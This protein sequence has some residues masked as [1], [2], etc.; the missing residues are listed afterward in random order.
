MVFAVARSADGLTLDSAQPLAGAGIE[1]PLGRRA[2]R[3]S[4]RLAAGVKR[5]ARA[6]SYTPA[7]S[8][9]LLARLH[10]PRNRTCGCDRDC[11]CNRTAI[12]RVVK[13]WFNGRLIGLQHK[14][15]RHSPDWKRAHDV[16]A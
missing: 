6:K 7:M 14:A 3:F 5:L 11:W 4:S 9:G 13:W 10:N 8:R 1:P 16:T 12:G 15:I 2:S